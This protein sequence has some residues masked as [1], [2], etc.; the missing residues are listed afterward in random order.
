MKRFIVLIIGL[1]LLCGCA[2]QQQT[3]TETSIETTTS[4]QPT[5]SMS[6]TTSTTTLQTTIPAAETTIRR[7]TLV[8]DCGD[9]YYYNNYTCYNDRVSKII[10][11]PLCQNGECVWRSE[12]EYFDKCTGGEGNDRKMCV[13]GFSKCITKGDYDKYLKIPVDAEVLHNLSGSYMYYDGYGF[14]INRF[15]YANNRV[16]YHALSVFIDVKKPS[17]KTA[18]L[19]LRW[20]ANSAIDELLVGMSVKTTAK[21]TTPLVWVREKD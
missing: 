10:Y 12:R 8:S 13:T 7:C 17:G 5:T 6:T 20:N 11:K 14:R 2:E 21:K 16:D 3:P 18:Q 15:E 1:V 19:E 9:A 4:A